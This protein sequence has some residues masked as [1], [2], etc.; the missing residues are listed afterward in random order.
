VQ[1]GKEI[2]RRYGVGV[3]TVSDIKKNGESIELFVSV[4]NP[5]IRDFDYPNHICH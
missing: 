4:F 5:I 1:S 2:A 3:A